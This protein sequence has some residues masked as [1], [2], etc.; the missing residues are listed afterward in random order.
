MITT[1]MSTRHESSVYIWLGLVRLK[2]ALAR[3]YYVPTGADVHVVLI[4]GGDET[5]PREQYY[6]GILFRLSEFYLS[7]PYDKNIYVQINSY[8]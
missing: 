3:E 5:V 7:Q 8:S 2:R 1:T 4:P 6:L